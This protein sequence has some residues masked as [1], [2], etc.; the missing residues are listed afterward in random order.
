MTLYNSLCKFGH[1]LTDENLV[2]SL[3]RNEYNRTWKEKH[4]RNLGIRPKSETKEY[5]VN[6]HLKK[7]N[8]RPNRYDCAVC[9]RERE[10]QR[11]R[12]NGAAPLIRLTREEK[13]AQ[14]RKWQHTRNAKKLEQFIEVVDPLVVYNRDKG[15]C[16][17]CHK[18]VSIDDYHID[19]IIPL[20]KGGEH[21]YNNV[22][23]AHSKC[24]LHKWANVP[25]QNCDLSDTL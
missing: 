24:N 22:Q 15:I 14:R 12:A 5:C 20:S 7:E 1:L 21:S 10:F 6:G 9:H 13:L 3:L 23:L 8:T 17:I 16:G 18:I 11:G 25:K 2:P 4:R 19:H